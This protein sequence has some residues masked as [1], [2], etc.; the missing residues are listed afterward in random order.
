VIGDVHIGYTPGQLEIR[1]EYTKVKK[2]QAGE[3]V[4]VRQKQKKF[5]KVL[6]LREG[7]PF[8]QIKANLSGRQ[9]TVTYPK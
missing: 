4:V 6:P 8:S 2:V 1:W 9:L 7:T 5:A 3:Q